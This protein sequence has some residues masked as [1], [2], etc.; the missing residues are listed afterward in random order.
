MFNAL[1]FQRNTIVQFLVPNY[2]GIHLKRSSSRLT[3]NKENI[4]ERINDFYLFFILFVFRVT[5]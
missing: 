2:S 1:S 3:L 4:L 5:L